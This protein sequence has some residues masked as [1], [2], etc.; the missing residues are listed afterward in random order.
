[1]A[2]KYNFIANANGLGSM[3]QG[4]D[5]IRTV[6]LTKNNVAIDITG[7]VVTF[8]AKS[9]YSDTTFALNATQGN[10]MIS[11]SGAEGKIYIIVPAAT[12]AAIPAGSYLYSFDMNLAGKT[13][14][15]SEGVLQNLPGV[16]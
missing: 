5:F 9:N 6:T 1:M 16:L 15:I 10:G 8:R 4:A 2:A 7:A 11:L 13:Y 14:R 3:D 12:T